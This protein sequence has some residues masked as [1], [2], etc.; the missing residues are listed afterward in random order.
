[1]QIIFD[2]SR[3]ETGIIVR[4][5]SV[6][7]PI[8][9]PRFFIL[10]LLLTLA[11]FPLRAQ[12]SGSADLATGLGGMTGNKDL[13]IGFLGHLLTQGNASVRYQSD[14][15]TWN[16]SVNGKWE[17]KSSDNSRLN[18]HAEAADRLAL[19]LVYKTVKTRP[20][21][22]GA[23]TEFGWKP[24]PAAEYSAWVSYQYQNDRARNVSNSLSGTLP[25]DGQRIR[26]YYESPRE[27]V[28]DLRLDDM[29]AH[30]ATCY[31]E[32]P[33]M[34]EHV[35]G[36][37]AR[38]KWKLGDKDLLQGY[39]SLSTT[40]SQRHTTWSV[41]RTTG[42]VPND[43]DIEAAFR[44][45][46]A[47]MYRITPSSIDLDFSA[48]VHLRH[49]VR[50]DSVRT[51]R[52]QPGIRVSGNHSLDHNS[53]ATLSDIG[54]DNTYQWRDSL[55][56]RET[57]DFLSIT[58]AP[59]LAF[60][61]S[62]QKLQVKADYALQFWLCRLND[63][64]HRQPIGLLGPYPD[65]NASL[66]WTLSD[67]HKLGV[68]HAVGVDYPNYFQLCWYDRTGGYVDQ[69]FRGNADLAASLHSRYG[70]TYELKLKRF[71]YKMRNAVT[72][73]IDEIDQTWTN[74]EIEG[75]LYKVFHWVNAADSWS[76]GTAHRVGYEGKSLKAGLGVEYNQS[77]RTAQTDG[78]RKDASDWRLTA[79]TDA[80]LGKGW[81][82]HADA[83]YQSKV[84]T[85]FTKFNEYWE[86]GLRIRKK[87]KRVTLYVD[88]R[89]LLDNARQTSFESADGQ[90]MWVDVAREN[91]RL[92]LAG[93]QWTF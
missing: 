86:V 60:E 83:K 36:T 73:R 10:L 9:K 6:S 93:I 1:M 24:S 91:R 8:M 34:D 65:G 88:G 70:M 79:D 51:V 46:D 52:W 50:S 5:I 21:Q 20:L 82:I 43:I 3:T 44:N 61:Y 71:R 81:L 89:D 58:P 26:H 35:M 92:F 40:S 74:E 23:R 15:F 77:R 75:R 27:L 69:L 84:A 33:R 67:R 11:A 85:F 30:L 55:R 28:D 80:D 54:P 32:T 72:R 7:L 39:F 4:E 13:N 2:G 87:F 14:Q 90:E 42:S 78:T 45:G 12:W 18:F 64:E 53:G 56:L 31:Y 68:T 41:F 25:L 38:G 62:A 63:E 22:V 16:A 48:D 76:F 47:W 49:T 29:D 17:P 66:T 37:G 19:E 59:Y 57:F